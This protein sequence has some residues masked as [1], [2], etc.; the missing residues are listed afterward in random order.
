M[1]KTKHCS[2]ESD[3]TNSQ[4]IRRASGIGGDELKPLRPH[5]S[6]GLDLSLGAYTRLLKPMARV[7]LAEANE[8]RHWRLGQDL[9]KPVNNR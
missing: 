2:S 9:A 7:T 5:P 6:R 1:T 8:R 4:L 3:V